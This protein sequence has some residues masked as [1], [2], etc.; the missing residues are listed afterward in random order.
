MNL[1]NDRQRQEEGEDENHRRWH[2]ANHDMQKERK[3]SKKKKAYAKNGTAGVW[4][5][6]HNTDLLCS[7]KS[8]NE[9]VR[10]SLFL[11]IENKS[12]TGN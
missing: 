7:K 1:E 5:S 12:R 8:Q 11:G 6:V 3:K 4:G 9:Y 10:Y 2:H